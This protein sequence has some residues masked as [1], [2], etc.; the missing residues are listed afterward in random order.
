[1]TPEHRLQ[2][3]YHYVEKWTG[4]RPQAAIVLGSGL[5]HYGEM[6][7]P[8]MEFDYREV[9]GWPVATAPGHKGKVIFGTRKGVRVAA[10]SGRFHCYEG[11]TPKETV[12]PLQ[13]ILLLGAKYVLLTNA[14]GAIHPRFRPGSLMLIEDHINLTGD[15]CLTG[16]NEECLGVRFPDVTH[17]YSRALNTALEKAAEAHDFYVERGVY[18]YM[19]GPSYETP[20]EIRALRILGADAVGMS[21]V[22]EAIACAHAG[23]RMA[24]I[25]CL[26]NLAAGVGAERLTE[27]EVLAAGDRASGQ[28]Q[29]LADGFLDTVAEWVRGG[30]S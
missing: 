8:E 23:A 5:N 9:P 30:A 6:I 12:I 20:A 17:M 28:M 11:Y 21:T 3:A 29:V 2:E 26:S 25:S 22:H 16:S 24:A 7:N 13:T 27:E 18:A 14:A 19:H 15:N 10:F 4:F 1:M